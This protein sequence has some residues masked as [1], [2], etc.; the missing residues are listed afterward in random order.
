MPGRTPYE[1]HEQT[2]KSTRPTDSR[3]RPRSTPYPP[4]ARNAE[5]HAVVAH[6]QITL[7]ITGRYHTAA[8][9]PIEARFKRGGDVK[10]GI[11]EQRGRE[12]DGIGDG[13]P[14]GTPPRT[15]LRT[16][17]RGDTP[18][19]GV[20]LREQ[21][22][23]ALKPVLKPRGHWS[24][25]AASTGHYVRCAVREADQHGSRSWFTEAGLTWV[26]A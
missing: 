16:G 7:Q 11:G 10:G 18:G 5:P 12:P 13:T 23:H 4:E 24:A 20:L 26:M 6:R 9:H 21:Q 15:G 17:L 22:E 19:F 8:P 3:A 1:P 2:S 14:C 25:R